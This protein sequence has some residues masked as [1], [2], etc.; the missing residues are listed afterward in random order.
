MKLFCRNKDTLLWRHNRRDG[1]SNQQ[2]HDCLLKCLFRPRSKKTPNSSASLA[3]VR[4][5]HRWSVNSP[6]KRSVTRQNVS[7]WWR[8]HEKWNQCNMV[9]KLATL[10][11][12]SISTEKWLISIKI[13]WKFVSEGPINK[14][15]ALGW[16]MVCHQTCDG[17]YAMLN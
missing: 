12:A 2:P 8:H 1:I 4:G 3:C 17:P 6:C 10:I 11:T 9:R 15:P 16:I 13:S 7:I 14:K 5:I